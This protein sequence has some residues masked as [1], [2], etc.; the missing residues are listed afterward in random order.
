VDATLGGGGHT[1]AFLKAF[2]EEPK[3]SKHRVLAFDRD[4]EAIARAET[5][6]QK[7]IADG[8]LTLVHSPFSEIGK[9][10]E[11]LDI[12][13]LL[14]DLGISSDQLDTARR[15]FGFREDGPLDMRMDPS[16]PVT[17]ATL[18]ERAPLPELEEIFKEEGEERFASRI[19]H[20][21]ANA[22][23]RKTLPRTTREFA[24][25]VF[26]AVP[27]FAR[28]GRIHPA[29]RVFQALRITVNQEMAELDALL[30]AVYHWMK[31]GGKVAVLSFHSGEDRR[32]KHAF[33]AHEERPRK[34]LTPTEEEIE[35]N[36]RSRSAKLR[37]LEIR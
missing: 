32:V 11:G 5:R 27:P 25:L 35:R 13:G 22:R 33:R 21:I 16:H 15:G 10:I 3:F 23:E 29:T 31:V 12:Y 1:A 9:H 19:V 37:V 20:A 4:P 14:A 34:P 28:H 36:P 6:F 26:R 30:G 18:L 7:E 24:E 8:K 17:A 2:A